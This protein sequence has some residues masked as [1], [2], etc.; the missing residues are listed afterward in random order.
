MFSPLG[1][2]IHFQ[3]K[4]LLASCP[5]SQRIG[6]FTMASTCNIET[7]NKKNKQKRADT[8]KVGDKVKF[9]AAFKMKTGTITAVLFQRFVVYYYCDYFSRMFFKVDKLISISLAPDFSI[10]VSLCLKDISMYQH[11]SKLS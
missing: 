5:S 8:F 1:I 3:K 4:L 2:L 9:Q 10:L 6:T 11:C 7:C